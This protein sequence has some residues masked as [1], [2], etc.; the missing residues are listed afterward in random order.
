MHKV[1]ALFR[2]QVSCT[3]FAEDF[4]LLVQFR[5]SWPARELANDFGAAGRRRAR[6]IAYWPL[7]RR[8]DWGLVSQ[9]NWT[10]VVA[11]SHE[12]RR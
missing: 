5:D 3:E 6:A 9:L 2:E 7:I 11:L 12:A 4:L 1:H 8:L 10:L